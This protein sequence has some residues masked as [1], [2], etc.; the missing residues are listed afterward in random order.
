MVY[1][2]MTPFLTPGRVFQQGGGPNGVETLDIGAPDELQ[3][4]VLAGRVASGEPYPRIIVG[5]P[6]LD[7]NYQSHQAP[8]FYYL[9]SAWMK[10]VGANQTIAFA[11]SIQEQEVPALLSEL[12]ENKLSSFG[13]QEAIQKEGLRI[14]FLNAL[15][16]GLTVLG[17]FA[18]GLYATTRASVGIAA[19][20][21]SSLLPMNIALSGSISNDPLLFCLC[22]WVIALIVR[23]LSP[24]FSPSGETICIKQALLIGLL[25]GLAFLTKTSA[26]L[27]VPVGIVAMIAGR[28]KLP[29][30]KMVPAVFLALLIGGIWWGRNQ[31]VYG[32]PFVLKTFQEAFQGRSPLAAD[33]IARV[34][35][36]TYWSNVLQIASYSLLGVFS[37]M[38]IYL[39][40]V[41]YKLATI[42]YVAV[43]MGAMV[44]WLRNRTPISASTWVLAS[45][46]LV[47]FLLFVQFNQQFFQAQARYL[48]PAI[49]P[50]AV[51]F[52]S[53]LH[54]WAKSRSKYGIA[55]VAI[56]LSLVNAY[57]LTILPDNFVSRTQPPQEQE[58]PDAQP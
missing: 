27:L 57:V 45:C 28:D 16:G 9:T 43:A 10:V 12:K 42:I 51:L 47:T 52:G 3:H 19:A 38:D 4:V 56:G 48:L 31:S 5:D 54:S 22:T 8:L 34:G 41:V 53:G 24:E 50:I 33:M 1:A 36:S 18:M 49:G 20:L 26:L 39:P 40:E 58:N 7:F 44:S 11:K 55:G 35:A 37:Y 29:L 17:C 6:K 21:V 46:G 30:K 14:R 32:E 13:G 2:S 25:V 15:I 23:A